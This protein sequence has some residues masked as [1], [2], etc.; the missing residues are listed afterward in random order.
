[1]IPRNE[2]AAGHD[3][4]GPIPGGRL[5][6]ASAFNVEIIALRLPSFLIPQWQRESL[7]TEKELPRG[8]QDLGTRGAVARIFECGLE[9]EYSGSWLS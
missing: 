3:A 5:S 1:M 2:P 4:S 6:V 8:R 7:R 9:D